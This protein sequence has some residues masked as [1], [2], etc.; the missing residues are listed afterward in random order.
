VIVPVCSALVRP[1]LEYCAQAWGPKH[2]K[3]QEAEIRLMQVGS[4][5]HPHSQAGKLRRRG[6]WEVCPRLEKLWS[7]NGKRR[8][9]IL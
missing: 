5:A 1:H 3:K 8:K 4:C 9:H 7:R 2:R 6:P